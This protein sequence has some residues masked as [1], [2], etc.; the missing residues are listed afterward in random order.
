MIM[1]PYLSAGRMGGR[2]DRGSGGGERRSGG[3]GGGPYG[4][5]TGTSPR[6]V[7]E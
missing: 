6:V 4:S 3:G 1:T 2:D 7:S 5:S